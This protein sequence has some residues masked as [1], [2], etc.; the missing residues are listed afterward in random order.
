MHRKQFTQVYSSSIY[1][2]NQFSILIPSIFSKSFVLSVTNVN[3]FTTEVT[4]INK[5][6]SSLIGF[7]NFLKRTFSLAYFLTEL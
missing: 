2:R 7:P 5:S 1:F 3:L 4:P 6:N